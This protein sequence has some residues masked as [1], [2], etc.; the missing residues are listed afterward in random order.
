[1]SI[2]STI[3]RNDYLGTGLVSSYDYNFKIFSSSDLRVTQT[4]DA[5][6][7][8]VLVLDTDYTV[9]GVGLSSGG[10][11]TLLGGALASNYTLT[12]RRV[13]DILQETEIRNS[14]SFYP[15]THEN[16]FDKFVM[17]DQQQQDELDR[18][19]KNPESIDADDFDPTLPPEIVDS[20]NATIIVNPTG[21]GWVIGPTESDSASAIAAGLSADEAAASAATVTSELRYATTFTF[22]WVT[23]SA[24]S[25][26][27]FHTYTGTTTQAFIG[28]GSLSGMAD[29]TMIYIIGTSDSNTLVIDTND[30]SNGW[31]C[32][33]TKE[34]SR[35]KVICFIY[36]STLGRMVEAS[37]V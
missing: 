20:P 26:R 36:N 4:T 14:G 3:S 12:I 33:G 11:I 1:M 9:S 28:F 23:P 13:I 17:I 24:T 37:Y 6:V 29:G 30:V 8:S 22:S 32:N 35:G 31:L 2:A 27:Q 21:T 7:P 18:S 25:T 15:V 10:S 5:G 34:L 19:V 16:A